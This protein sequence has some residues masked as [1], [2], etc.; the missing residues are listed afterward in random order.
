MTG[1]PEPL[2][3]RFWMT[4]AALAALGLGLRIAAAQGALW[5]D[6]AWSAWSAH[7]L[8]APL[9]VFAHFHH[10]NNHHL[11]TLWLQLVGVSAPPPLQRGLSILCG[12]LA[13]PLAAAIAG[14]RGRH[15]GIVAA[16]LFAVAPLLVIY[17]S[18]AR[19]YAPMLLALLVAVLLTA[20]W[21]DDPDRP[22]PAIPLTLAVLFGLLGQ[23]TFAFGAAALC[24]WVVIA[25]LQR[26]SRRDAIAAIARYAL[27]MAVAGLSTL[28]VIFVPAQ[29]NG[30]MRFGSY[31]PFDWGDWVHGV[32]MM[33][34]GSTGGLIG[35]AAVILLLSLGLTLRGQPRMAGIEGYL[36]LALAG[37]LLVPLFQLGNAG[38][39][40]YYLAAA[41]ALLLLAAIAAGVALRRPGWPRG[42]TL[43]LLAVP[44][45]TSL[46]ADRELIAVQR[47]DP[48]D[49][50]TA[51]MRRA[52]TGARVAIEMSRAS[53]VLAVAASQKRYRLRIVGGACPAERFLFLDKTGGP[54]PMQPERCGARYATIAVG[55]TSSL[56]G[57]D[58]KLYERIP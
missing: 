57:M 33:L 19:G 13:I 42:L 15:A 45:V 6:E 10:D 34:T 18:E 46:I 25:L 17:G 50:I 35:I 12:T 22:V 40:R 20:R 31:T 53:A 9:A 43:G 55:K 37:V 3:R 49:A 21:L 23:L 51:M 5:L 4:V 29:R 58:W 36:R 11:N 28:A 32:A 56:T 16:L 14:R 39:S 48:G 8:G 27:P 1:T 54:L 47:G 30:G 7:E 52:P 44:T 24:L 41:T 26:R 38:I 2:H